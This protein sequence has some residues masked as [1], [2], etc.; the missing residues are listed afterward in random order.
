MSPYDKHSPVAA[1]T[2][3]GLACEL[4]SIIGLRKMN[5]EQKGTFEQSFK[6]IPI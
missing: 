6:L 1:M 3:S 5:I 4:T 2:I